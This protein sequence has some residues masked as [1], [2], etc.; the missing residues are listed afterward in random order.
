VNTIKFTLNN[1]E[2]SYPGK[3]T[4]RLLD[5]LRNHFQLTGVKCGCKEGEC[6]ACAVIIDGEL[7]NS[8]M[9]AIGACEGSEV[10]TIEG[11]RETERFAVVDRVYAEVSAVQHFIC[12]PEKKKRD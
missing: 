9:V 8:C 2:V 5:V 1:Q 10:L 4:D 11:Y 7:I 6:G 12:S 3:A